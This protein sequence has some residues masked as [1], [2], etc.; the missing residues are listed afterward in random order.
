MDRFVF[1][2][3]SRSW[4]TARIY[5]RQHHTDLTFIRNQT[6]SD[7]IKSMMQDAKLPKAWIGLF[8]D[9][10]R[11]SD[12]TNVNTTSIKWMK[13][14]PDLSGLNRPCG[15]TGPNHLIFDEICSKA[16]NFVCLHS[17]FQYNVFTVC[18]L[19]QS[20]Q[21]LSQECWVDRSLAKSLPHFHLL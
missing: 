2:E 8:R 5:C 19:I 4:S 17:E 1:V 20:R 9:S 21:Q 10:W 15:A 18:M 6:D 11:W 14:Q 13:G 12:G 3:A 16:F 7:Q